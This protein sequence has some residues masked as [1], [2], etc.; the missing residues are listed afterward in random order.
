LVPDEPFALSLVEEISA[1]LNKQDW[2][3]VGD[4]AQA[5]AG[6]SSHHSRS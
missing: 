4:E 6:Y 2:L 1:R 5:E 3:N